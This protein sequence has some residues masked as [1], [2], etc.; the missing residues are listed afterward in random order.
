MFASGRSTV[1]LAAFLLIL[2]S[3]IFW[4]YVLKEKRFI[5]L[6]RC[7]TSIFK[8]FYATSVFGFVWGIFGTI[9]LYSRFDL[10]LTKTIVVLSRNSLSTTH[11]FHTH[12]MKVV[13]GAII[14]ILNI[15][16]SNADTGVSFINFLPTYYIV[17]ASI[18]LIVVFVL[19]IFS[20]YLLW[21]KYSNKF[22]MQ[23]LLTIIVF[24]ITKNVLDGGLLSYET[25][26]AL[27][28]FWIIIFG[29]EWKKAYIP[30]IFTAIMLVSSFLGYF[31]HLNSLEEIMKYFRMGGVLFVSY[32][33]LYS[34][35]AGLISY[36][37]S[38]LLC[39]IGII[40]VVYPNYHRTY[41]NFEYLMMNAQ[42]KISYLGTYK[43][44]I[45]EAT[46]IDS[47]GNLNLFRL[48]KKSEGNVLNIL[49]ESGDNVLYYP[50]SIEWLTCSP[51]SDNINK[52][53][54]ILSLEAISTTT[55]KHYSVDISYIQ[56]KPSAG[57]FNSYNI[58]FSIQPCTPRPINFIQESLKEAG[59][60]DA[61]IYFDLYNYN[62]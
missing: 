58:T 32:L 16:I 17:I 48:Q 50:V 53:L 25:I 49:H 55:N 27:V 46:K 56:K 24:S 36:R 51:A 11:L 20:I 60:V 7:E 1:K 5:R 37:L 4:K 2:I 21:N 52:S 59:L 10:P 35:S 29:I 14:N 3:L 43:D 34:L 57:K 31:F 13:T 47:I 44:S 23:L 28:I 26:P 54:D 42:D 33:G 12:V 9:L 41:G 39:V 8:S 38:I 40:G 15:N 61:V 30:L 22:W 18:L 6:I 19:S 62:D 45:N